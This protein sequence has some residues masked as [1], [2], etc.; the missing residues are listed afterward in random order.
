MLRTMALV[1]STMTALAAAS[2]MAMAVT[3]ELDGESINM[4]QGNGFTAILQNI[5]QKGTEL[6]GNAKTS[7]VRGDFTGKLSSSGRFKVTV[8][9]DG[10]SE[11]VYTAHVEGDGTVVDGRTYDK[12]HPESW[13]TWETDALPC[14]P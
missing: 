14:D 12:A 7:T 5:R 4:R 11:G 9:W 8:D 6:S 1:F 3:C 2:P 10:D 13:A